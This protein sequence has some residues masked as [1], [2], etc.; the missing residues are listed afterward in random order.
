MER[1]GNNNGNSQSKNPQDESRVIE[2]EFLIDSGATL[3]VVS[4]PLLDRIGVTPYR[5]QDF[6][7]ADGRIIKRKVGDA[8]FEYRD[9][10]SPSPVVVGEQDDT[11]LLGTLTLE[12]MGLVLDP[13]KRKLCPAKL[14]L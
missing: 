13:F 11:L 7:L 10:R 9:Y 1:R 3:S 6:T 14:T 12:G 2:E 5:E 4:K 8:V